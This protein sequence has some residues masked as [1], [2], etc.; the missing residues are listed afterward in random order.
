MDKL[1]IFITFL[2][3]ERGQRERTL[4]TNRKMIKKILR[5]IVPLSL[6][7]IGVFISS[8]IEKQAS[9]S[10]I[11]QHI[12]LLRQWGECFDL[13]FKNYP[14]PKM[15][16]K[17]EFKREVFADQEILDFLALPNP[18]T[19][20]HKRK[21]VYKDRYDMWIIFYTVLFYHGCRTLEIAQLEVDMFDFGQNLINLPSRI[22]KTKDARSIPISPQVREQLYRY[23]NGLTQP[24]LFPS[25][26]ESTKER[27][28][29]HV[30]QMDWNC[31]F[32]KQLERLGIKRKNLTPYSGRHSYGT[33]QAEEDVHLSKIK[34]IMGH[35][36]ITTTEGYIHLGMKALREVQDNDRLRRKSLRYNQRYMM[37]REKVRKELLNFAKTPREERKML[38]ALLN[39]S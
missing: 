21:G 39:L 26:H 38:E 22:T 23:V 10:Y 35:K 13:E 7:T 11:K 19:K 5:E 6:P 12:G 20:T 4:Q 2:Q 17:S 36:R 18:Y 30:Q 24:Y 31:F 16:H 29:M 3:K 28:V 25:F 14:Y 8:L 15:F 37:F 34:G 32:K 9:P 27:G 33:R 1:E